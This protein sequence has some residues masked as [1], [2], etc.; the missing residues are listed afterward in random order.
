MRYSEVYW[1]TLSG[2]S[3]PSAFIE[4]F[5]GRL[6][7]ITG[8]EAD[9]VRVTVDG[10]EESV[11]SFE[12]Y[13]HHYNAYLYSHEDIHHSCS[14]VHLYDGNGGEYRK[15]YHGFASPIAYVLDSPESVHVLPMQIDT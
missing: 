15:S 10:M 12:V 2:L 8:Y 1:T 11:P 5:Q 3:L 9:I 6:V 13:N 7:A 4:R 14:R